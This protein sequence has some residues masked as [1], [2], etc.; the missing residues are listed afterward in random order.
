M[1]ENYTIGDPV[2]ATN[3]QNANMKGEHESSLLTGVEAPNLAAIKQHADDACLID[4]G[5]GVRS[6]PDSRGQH[7]KRSGSSSHPSV[8]IVV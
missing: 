4:S 6:L 2:G 8:D 1:G 7:V 5:F 3:A